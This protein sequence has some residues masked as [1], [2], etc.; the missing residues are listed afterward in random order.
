MFD[1][2]LDTLGQVVMTRSFF[3]FFQIYDSH[4]RSRGEVYIRTLYIY[5]C[6]PIG[7]LVVPING[8]LYEIFGKEVGHV[9]KS[10]WIL[11]LC[12]RVRPKSLRVA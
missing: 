2:V 10:I 1:W 12:G 3:F 5:I 8:R 6:I 4:I 9:N 7:R 11:H